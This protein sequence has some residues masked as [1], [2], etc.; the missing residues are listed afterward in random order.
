MNGDGEL[1]AVNIRYEVAALSPG[2]GV[3]NDDNFR[4]AVAYDITSNPKMY[5][6]ALTVLVIDI[7]LTLTT[8]KYFGDIKN[9]YCWCYGNCVSPTHPSA[10]VELVFVAQPSKPILF[11]RGYA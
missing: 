8:R 6:C 2:A 4:S 5:I 10:S 3:D 9:I 7:E 1:Q 11:T